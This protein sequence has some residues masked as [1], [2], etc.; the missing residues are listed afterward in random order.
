MLHGTPQVSVLVL[1]VKLLFTFNSFDSVGVFSVLK[2]INSVLKFFLNKTHTQLPKITKHLLCS[3]WVHFTISHL[4][5]SW[6]HLLISSNNVSTMSLNEIWAFAQTVSP[7]VLF[8]EFL[9]FEFIKYLQ[10]S[11]TERFVRLWF[12]LCGFWGSYMLEL[13]LVEQSRQRRCTTSWS[14]AV[15]VRLPGLVLSFFNNPCCRATAAVS[16]PPVFSQV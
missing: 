6:M 4:S 16:L 11:H 3:L 7:D 10:P 5:G 13:F 8:A 15:T 14:L 1:S 12:E 2:W 9:S